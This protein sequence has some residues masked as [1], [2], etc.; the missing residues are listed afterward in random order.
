M[1]SIVSAICK[2]QKLFLSRGILSMTHKL[3]ENSLFLMH[4]IFVNQYHFQIW[5]PGIFGVSMLLTMLQKV[6]RGYQQIGSFVKVYME[7]ISI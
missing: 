6:H 7:F 1:R 5:I 3:I 4:L 2:Q